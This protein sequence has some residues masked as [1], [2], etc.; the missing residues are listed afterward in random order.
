VGGVGYEDV[1]ISSRDAL[2]DAAG[3]PIVGNDGR[4]VTNDAAPR[5]IA[6]ATDGLIWDV[7]VMWRPSRRTAVEAYV[8]ERYGTMTYHGTLSYAPDSRTSLNVAVYDNVTGFGG[9]LVDQLA[10]LPA[11]FDAFR[12]PISGQI[13]GCVASPEGDG[14][15]ASAL[16]SIRSAA[17]RSRGIAASY[18][19]T[20]G[21]TQFGTGVG[22]DHRRFVAAPGTVLAGADGIVDETVWLALYGTTEIDARSSVTAN[23]TASWFQSSVSPAFDV[24][25]YSASVAYYR[26]LMPRLTGTAA[27]GLDGISR[28]NLPDFLSASA[29]LGLRYSFN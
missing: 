15:F 16:G 24:L 5:Q 6:Y 25:G 20:L 23:A 27:V 17:F 10:G 1:E 14:C 22:Y 7:G 29:L 4:Y 9:A 21:R 19:V 11:Q 2:R 18:S 28:D 3:N 8:G 26:D 12:N 13:G